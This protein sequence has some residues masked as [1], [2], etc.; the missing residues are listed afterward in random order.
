MKIISKLILFL[1]IFAILHF[2]YD[3]FPNAVVKIFSS[4]DESVFSHLKMSFWAYF[5]ILLIDYFYSK[6]I[7]KT[8]SFIASLLITIIVPYFIIIIWYILPALNGKIEKEIFE[9]L[10][11]FIV[12]VIVSIISF[13]INQ[14]LANIKFNRTVKIFIILLFFYLSSFIH[15]LPFQNHG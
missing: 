1:L 8:F 6:K 10:W 13:N 5:F 9:I 7:G 14:D 11:A 3:F 2:A 12:L 4:S 15:T